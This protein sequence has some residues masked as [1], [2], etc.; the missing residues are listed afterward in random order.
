M[1]VT[2]F[3]DEHGFSKQE[4]TYDMLLQQL[5][6]PPTAHKKAGLPLLKLGTF[7][8]IKTARGSYRSNNNLM[9]MCG[10]ELDYDSELVPMT[11]CVR[12]LKDRGLEAVVYPS[13]SHTAERPRYRVLLPF[14]KEFHRDDY[15]LKA[16]RREAIKYAEAALGFQFASESYTLSQAFYF[17]HLPST[18]YEFY[19][20]PGKHIDRL[21]PWSEIDLGKTDDGDMP[22]FISTGTHQQFN[23]DNAIEDI[24]LRNGY[25]QNPDNPSRF[26]SPLSE[27][28]GYGV[29][30]YPPSAGRPYSTCHTNHDNDLLIE[31]DREDP[32][33]THDAFDCYRILEHGGSW[34]KAYAALKATEAPDTETG[35]FRPLYQW[36][37]MDIPS[38][39]TRVAP[40]MSADGM[41][42]L[43]AQTGVGKSWAAM[44]L[45]VSLVTGRPWLGL[46]DVENVIADDETVIYVDGEMPPDLL[47]KRWSRMLAAMDEDEA[48]WVE[49]H[50]IVFSGV[51]Y[52]MAK[53]SSINLGAE[54]WRS[55]IEQK[56]LD[57]NAAFVCLDNKSSLL[58][59]GEE[60]SNDGEV[61]DI[62]QWLMRLRGFGIG[63]LV[64]LHE[65]NTAGRSRG[66]SRWRDPMDWVIGLKERDETNK[67][68]FDLKFVKARRGRPHGDLAQPTVSLVDCDGGVRLLPSSDPEDLPSSD[69][70]QLLV[71]IKEDSSLSQR[72]MAT[73]IGWDQAKVKRTKA[74]LVEREFLA[75]VRGFELTQ[76]GA[77]YIGGVDLDKL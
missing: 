67:V 57:L 44:D 39:V 33:R 61:V 77:D 58:L 62:T 9:T 17:G 72:A 37:D 68:Q 55:A 8:D 3:E 64:V 26:R 43:H 32:K 25:E 56:A 54:S 69:E 5:Q 18:P 63:T 6:Q 60:N 42:M 70:Q 71:A 76:S 7:G 1:Q 35:M 11:T 59:D 45:C 65:G 21:M 66:G 15:P 50:V 28:N 53:R 27:S 23:Q 22:E 29:V 31:G 34:Q 41:G 16:V 75:G 52:A 40:F 47:Q 10:V 36:Q 2:T 4:I 74:K 38:V 14:S 46:Y 30:V 19:S 51:E 48:Q 12:L 24:L 73:K 49:Q 20:I 13:P